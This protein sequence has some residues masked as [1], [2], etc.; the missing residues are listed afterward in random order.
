MS[1]PQGGI[2]FVLIA[3]VLLITTSPFSS[4]PIVAYADDVPQFS[5]SDCDCPELGIPLEDDDD[6]RYSTDEVVGLHCRYDAGLASRR[7][8]LKIMYFHDPQDVPGMMESLEDKHINYG[9]YDTMLG[10]IQDDDY[11][12]LI[13]AS[14]DSRRMSLLYTYREM[15]LMKGS[16][17][18]RHGDHYVVSIVGEGR[19]FPCVAAFEQ[20]F[21]LLEQHAV[22]VIEGNKEE[23]FTFHYYDAFSKED[24]PAGK[25]P[26]DL[27]A[28]LKDSEGRGIPG[29]EIYLFRRWRSAEDDTFAEC[30]RLP[31]T[32]PLYVDDESLEAN[33]LSYI[34]RREYLCDSTD[35][36]LLGGLG[37]AQLYISDAVDFT[38]LL[39]NLR[40]YG[41]V[42]GTVY[43][44]VFDKSPK[45]EYGEGSGARVEH[46]LSVPITIKGT[47]AIIGLGATDKAKDAKVKLV[48]DGK[49]VFVKDGNLP[50]FLLEDRV[51]FDNNA[52]VTIRWLNGMTMTVSVRENFLE[53]NDWEWLEINYK[54]AGWYHWFDQTFGNWF[55]EC[56]LSLA[57][58]AIGLAIGGPA[59]ALAGGPIS[60][61]V[62]GIILVYEGLQWAYDPLIVRAHS[63]IL[64]ELG[65]E[66]SVYMAEGKATL[67]DPDDGSSIDI[68]AGHMAT[69]SREGEFGE[70]V[71]F[72]ESDLDPDMA[73]VYTAVSDEEPTSPEATPS[74][75][76]EDDD[77][78]GGT[79]VAAIV[80]PIVIVVAL[81]VLFIAAR[82]KRK[83]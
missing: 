34:D 12:V 73:R 68:E 2:R 51:Y 20:A 39:E 66:S 11:Y 26:G 42:S 29:E 45:Q 70:V 15:A 19:D 46:V 3:L 49:D 62:G 69:V 32:D 82:R 6:P 78:D 75:V 71:A 72:D 79:N 30:V 31:D 9:D 60:L 28:T 80:V 18:F 48:V 47:A 36:S 10:E 17:F 50:F 55:V 53:D 23:H 4:L 67:Y 5:R 43:A 56:T 1:K 16:R 37:E 63:V 24:P 57:P 33:G 74:S 27:V 41:E 65:E 35:L 14:R 54:D 76:F 58:T 61:L 21:D 44:V 8:D 25:S 59:G 77:D 83:A 38:A 22:E 52:I 40:Q 64:V 7:V 13:E 81:V